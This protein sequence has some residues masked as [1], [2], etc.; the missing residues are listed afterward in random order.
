MPEYMVCDL[1][2]PLASWGEIV[3]GELRTSQDHPTKSAILGMLGAALGLERADTEA[4]RALHAGLHCAMCVHRTGEAMQD[5]HTTQS[6]EGKGARGLTTRKDELEYKKLATILSRRTYLCDS[7]V[8]V[9]L[10]RIASRDFPWSLEQLAD[11]MNAPVWTLSLGRKSCVPD[12]PPHARCVQADS[13]NEVLQRSSSPV[14]QLLG[15]HA[16]DA[17]QRLYWDS[18]APAHEVGLRAQINAMRRD[19]V[20]NRRNWTFANRQESS[21]TWPASSGE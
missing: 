17:T 16:R 2:G 12:V 8:T 20:I 3:A 19:S 18:D 5:F 7:W 10:W 4:H 15:R 13:V 9:V 11:A 14:E 6:P 1:H 21:A